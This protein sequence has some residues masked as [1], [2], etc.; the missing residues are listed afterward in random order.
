MFYH[1]K[2]FLFQT[3]KKNINEINKSDDALRNK[4]CL[5]INL[6]PETDEDVKLANLIQYEQI[7]GTSSTFIYLKDLMFLLI[8]GGSIPTEKEKKSYISIHLL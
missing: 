5:D 7:E 2:K 4:L 8:R 6:V 1:Y 3:E